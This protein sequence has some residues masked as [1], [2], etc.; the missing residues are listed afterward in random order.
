MIKFNLKVKLAEKEINQ[1]TFSKLTGIGEN[2]ITRYV[3]GSF[4][5]ID[6]DHLE[7][8]C[9]FFECDISE[10]IKYVPDEE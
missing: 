1:K 6:K 8:M 5:K 10:I 7:K 4:I 3:N 2:S 9:K